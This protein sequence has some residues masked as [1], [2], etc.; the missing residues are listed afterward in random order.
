[1][2]T[3]FTDA[4]NRHFNDAELLLDKQRF[5]NA[6]HL[7]GLAA[8]C[9]LKALMVKFGMPLSDNSPQDR[10]DRVHADKIWQRYQS[11]QSGHIAGAGYGLTVQNP[12]SAWSVH[13]RYWK[14]SCITEQ[15]A[16]SHQQGAS[17]VESLVK[18]AQLAGLL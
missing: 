4:F 2:N 12:F 14:S 16:Q 17:Q 13:Q 6:S 15:N 11:Y 8:E 18:K 7:Y 5:A 1:M 10:N 9:G 3:N